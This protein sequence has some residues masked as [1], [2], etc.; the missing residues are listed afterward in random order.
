M[1]P[2]PATWA[3]AAMRQLGREDS[4]TPYWVHAIIVSATWPQACNFG[5]YACTPVLQAA[6]VDCDDECCHRDCPLLCRTA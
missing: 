2:S 1:V 3:A 6:Q 5:S 4:I